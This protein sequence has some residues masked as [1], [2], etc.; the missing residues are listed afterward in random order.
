MLGYL[1]SKTTHLRDPAG[2]SKRRALLDS[3]AMA[4]GERVA[5]VDDEEAMTAVTST[6]L[7][8]LGYSTTSYNSASRFMEAFSAAPDRI[9]LVVADVVMPGMSGVHLV[10]ALRD[11]GHDIPI[12]LMTGYTV[13]PRLQP[14]GS[15]GRISFVRKPFTTAHLAQ[16]VRRLLS[17]R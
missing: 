4:R 5:I 1:R 16:S 8:R 6:L 13:Q 11:S 15:A 12:L 2:A 10:H 7:K 14:G 17:D 3:L 9:D